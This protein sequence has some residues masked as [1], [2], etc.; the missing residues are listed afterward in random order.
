MSRREDDHTCHAAG[1]DV[2]VPPRMF[3]CRR[4]WFTLPMSMRN[5]I[6]AAYVPGQEERMD[7]TDAYIEVASRAV[8]WLAEKEKENLP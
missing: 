1:C 2:R 7:P 8:A 6:W 4:H 5:E 3:M